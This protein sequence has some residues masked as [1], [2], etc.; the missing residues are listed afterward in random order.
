MSTVKHSGQFQKGVSG[1]PK[2]RP[3]R[4]KSLA[5]TLRARMPIGKLADELIRIAL[6]GESDQIKLAAMKT[7][8]EFSYGK[9]VDFEL[10]SRLADIENQIG[11]LE[12]KH[13]AAA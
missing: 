3:R 10:Q 4:G 5:E 9:P 7:L 1:N 11:E 6:D 8:F 12:A 2:G 13:D